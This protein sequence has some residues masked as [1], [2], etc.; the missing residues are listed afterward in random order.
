M[1]AA[2]SVWNSLGS[3]LQTA[4]LV[5]IIIGAIYLFNKIIRPAITC[6][7]S[8]L[9]CAG[10]A[11]ENTGA[12]IST[13]FDQTWM[14]FKNSND[15]IDKRLAAGSEDKVKLYAE[16]AATVTNFIPIVVVGRALTNFIKGIWS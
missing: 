6:I 13:A 4:L 8:P 15:S 1:G 10:R 7:F 2:L 3:F 5:T 9:D 16:K 12:S 11:I 14:K